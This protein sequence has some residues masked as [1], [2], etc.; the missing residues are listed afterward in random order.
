[1]TK[2]ENKITVDVIVGFLF[3]VALTLMVVLVMNWTSDLIL[4]LQLI[5]KTEVN[6]KP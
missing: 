5:E 3:G 1:M 4:K 2:R 6:P